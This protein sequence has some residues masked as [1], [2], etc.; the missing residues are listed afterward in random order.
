MDEDLKAR[1]LKPR[2]PEGEV[3]LGFGTVR[4][5]GLSR[6]E[7]FMVQQLK[8]TELQERRTL[9]LGMLDPTMTEAEVG[10]WQR[11]S[12]AGEIEPVTEKIRDLSGVGANSEKQAMQTFRDDSG[13]GVRVPAG[14]EAVDDGGAAPGADEQ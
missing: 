6:G 13:D 12:P 7:V 9:A 5:R 8:G 4:V 3:E 1:L 11:S 10:Q 2:L 14:D